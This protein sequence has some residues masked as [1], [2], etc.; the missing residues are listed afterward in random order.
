[1]E[2]TQ[3]LDSMSSR[4]HYGVYSAYDEVMAARIKRQHE[5]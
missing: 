5:R 3:I 2:R 1:M 4:R